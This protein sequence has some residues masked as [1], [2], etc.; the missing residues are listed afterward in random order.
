MQMKKLE[1]SLGVQLFE[2]VGRRIY[3]TFNGR[4]F[5]VTCQEIFNCVT[6]FDEQVATQI[7]L[8]GGSLTFAGVTTTEYF[9][10]ALLGVFKKLY[11]EVN[12]S[13]SI[14]ERENLFHRLKDNLDDLYLIDQVPIYIEVE[15]VPFIENP[16]VVVASSD[17]H[18]SKRK[19]IPLKDLE[20]EN[21]LLR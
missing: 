17:H 10:P 14:L 12:F 1:D 13:L 15:S 8:V 18:L 19:N 9:V 7:E 20:Q 16:V 2:Q 11:P 21:I 4:V 6:Q 5:L 3:P